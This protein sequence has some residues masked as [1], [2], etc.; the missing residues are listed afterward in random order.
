MFK[1]KVNIIESKLPPTNKNDWWFDLNTEVMKQWKNGDW[2]NT[3]LPQYPSHTGVLLYKTNNDSKVTSTYDILNNGTIVVLD[4][5]YIPNKVYENNSTLSTMVLLEG[6]TSIEENAF[7]KCTSLGRI[8]LPNS[9]KTIKKNAFSGCNLL[10]YLHIPDNIDVIEPMSLPTGN[11]IM[12][13]NI[14]GNGVIN[15]VFLTN[16]NSLLFTV[17]NIAS[18][19]NT[20]DEDSIFISLPSVSYLAE[21]SF[22]YVLPYEVDES[23]YTGITLNIP[24]SVTSIHPRAF[25]LSASS[26]DKFVGKFASKDGLYL[27]QDNILLLYAGHSL[28]TEAVVDSNINRVEERAFQ[29]CSNLTTIKLPA[30]LESIG[31]YA[32]YGCSKLTSLYCAATVPPVI[33]KITDLIPSSVTKIYVPANSVSAYKSATNWSTHASKIVGYNF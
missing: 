7:N 17:N 25:L 2:V 19:L 13:H 22:A 12:L 6:I 8:V 3:L 10:N 32:F 20:G 9:L 33:D 27:Y 26:I 15:N 18:V 16:S 30:S 11:N 31:A 1:N 23:V 5:N 4:R 24:N 29:N 21:R 28:N 14:S